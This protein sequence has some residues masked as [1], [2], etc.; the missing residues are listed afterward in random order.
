VQ[1]VD[2]HRMTKKIVNEE[3]YSR[4]ERERPSKRGKRDV[5]ENV[6]MMIIRGWRMETQD[7]KDWSRT[8]RE[9]EVHTGLQRHTDDND[10]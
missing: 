1:S 6:R 10:D 8:V 4:Y 9:V 5:N 2:D 7:R 3:M